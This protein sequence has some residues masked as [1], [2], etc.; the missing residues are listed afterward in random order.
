MSL[1]SIVHVVLNFLSPACLI[2]RRTATR[3]REGIRQCSVSLTNSNHNRH[4]Q[5]SNILFFRHRANQR[6]PISH[7]ALSF[8]KSETRRVNHFRKRTNLKFNILRISHLSVRGYRRCRNRSENTD[9]SFV[10]LVESSRK[11]F[12]LR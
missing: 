5:K 4:K 12:F 8:S 3:R 7:R 10:F 6:S 11:K 2:S 9:E 1:R